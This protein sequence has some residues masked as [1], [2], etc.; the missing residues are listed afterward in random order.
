MTNRS[1]LFIVTFV[2]LVRFPLVLLFFTGALFNI[3]Y[4]APWLFVAAFT[5]LVTSAV[6][7]LVDGYLARK[8]GVVTK[9]GEHADPLM[10]KF[11]YLSTLPLL[12]FIATKNNHIPHAMFLLVLTV[13]FLSRDQWVTFLRSIGS[14]YNVSGGANWSGKFRTL[15]NFPLIC[16]VYYMEEASKPLVGNWVMY[17]ME[18]AAFVLNL[19]SFY[20]YTRRYWPYLLKSTDN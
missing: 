3:K 1:K 16:L 8:F 20:V 11:F 14:M 17:V 5:M 2:T 13:F 6:T 15:V 19:V 7:D 12:V 9:F 10:D 4:Q 18:G